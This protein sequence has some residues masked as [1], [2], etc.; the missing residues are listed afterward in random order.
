MFFLKVRKSA[1]L[2]HTRRFV[3]TLRADCAR[4]R[5]LTRLSIVRAS[6]RMYLPLTAV[7]ALRA[8]ATLAMMPTGVR[9]RGQELAQATTIPTAYFSKVM[10]Q[11]VVAGLV[12][13]EK[14]HGGGFLLARAPNEITFEAILDAVGVVHPDSCAFGWDACNSRE[15]CPL[16]DSWSVLKTMFHRW[17]R[18]TT[19]ADVARNESPLVRLSTSKRHPAND[20]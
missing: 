6:Q 8:M 13:S 20:A 18:E 19:L 17:S 3:P 11:L 16:H 10:R 15:P 1:H 12:L 4:S 2:V 14:G 9:A 5:E 7:Y